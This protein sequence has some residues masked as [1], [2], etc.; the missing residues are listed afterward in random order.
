[1]SYAGEGKCPVGKCPGGMSVYRG[2]T[3]L[4]TTLTF[5]EFLHRVQT[6]SGQWSGPLLFNALAVHVLRT[7]PMA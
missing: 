7:G 6:C 3:S 4:P 2:C 1:M 5:K